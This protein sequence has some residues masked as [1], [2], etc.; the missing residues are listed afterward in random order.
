MFVA[1]TVLDL[2]REKQTS[3]TAIDYAFDIALNSLVWPLAGYVWGLLMWEFA[4]Y[5]NEKKFPDAE[6]EATNQR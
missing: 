3:H 5:V 4:A 2:I 6:A 1:M